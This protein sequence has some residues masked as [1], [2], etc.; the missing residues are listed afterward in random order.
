[1]ADLRFKADQRPTPLVKLLQPG[2]LLVAGSLDRL[3]WVGRCGEK[4]ELFWPPVTSASVRSWESQV[5]QAVPVLRTAITSSAG[6]FSFSLRRFAAHA[7]QA[8]RQPGP[9]AK[10][11]TRIFIPPVRS[12]VGSNGRIAA[13]SRPKQY[14]R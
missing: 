9:S 8:G 1:M 14:D 11:V 6:R 10:S 13:A 12:E 4:A 5:P 7:G 3:G 2:S